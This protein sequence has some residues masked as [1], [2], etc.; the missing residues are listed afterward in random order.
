MQTAD[1][2]LHPEARSIVQR[3][4][5][6]HNGCCGSRR[7]SPCAQHTSRTDTNCVD[8]GLCPS[9]PAASLCGKSARTKAR[10]GAPSWANITAPR[11]PSRTGVAPRLFR[12]CV[13]RF[14]DPVRVL[15]LPN[16]CRGEIP[17]G[18]R[19]ATSSETSSETALASSL[20]AGPEYPSGSRTG[21]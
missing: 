15:P 7:S 18:S 8:A 2:I 5:R 6:S 9:V 11:R 3:A 10:D 4:P 12:D 1:S 20:G 14:R 16:H 13:G 17:V 19:S 21:S